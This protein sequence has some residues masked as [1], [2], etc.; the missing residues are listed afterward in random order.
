MEPVQ[1]SAFYTLLNA[2][3]Q[4]DLS[5]E[6]E[7][8][9]ML[10][11]FKDCVNSTGPLQELGQVF[12]HIGIMELYDYAGTKDIQAIGS[13]EAEQWKEIE[14]AKESELH[15]QLA[16]SMIAH[17]KNNDL[18]KQISTK[19]NSSKREI[20]KNIIGMARY[21]TEGIMDAIE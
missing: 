7:Y 16:N 14:E 13:L 5:K 3:K 20:N 21:I 9:S 12:L 1:F 6:E 19:W 11:D 17:A 18:P 4:G 2:L 10:A 8:Q 15:L